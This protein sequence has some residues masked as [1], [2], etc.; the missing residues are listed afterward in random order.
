[1]RRLV[2]DAS[3]AL[4]W[5]VAEE[6]SDLAAALRPNSELIAPDLLLAEVANA[7]WK[8]VRRREMEPEDAD[9]AIQL[10]Q[11]VNVDFRSSRP[12]VRPA[13]ALA[14]A[15]EI[16]HPVYDC[17]YLAL[18]RAEQCALVTADGRL[19]RRAAG[20]LPPGDLLSLNDAL[21]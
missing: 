6:G 19:L 1:M 7:L 20:A 17:I 8:K 13:L 5:L 15:R 3:V 18:A 9:L 10:L 14:L 2:V 4:K 16:D 21:A 11:R 12:L